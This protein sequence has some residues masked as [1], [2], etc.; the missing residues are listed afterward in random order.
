MNRGSR[1]ITLKRAYGRPAPAD[2]QRFL[3]ERRLDREYAVVPIL[4]FMPD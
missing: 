3:V 1:D 4:T 2:G